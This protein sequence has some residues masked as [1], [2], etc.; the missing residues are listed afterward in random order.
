MNCKLITVFSHPEVEGLHKLIQS[1]KKFGWAHNFVPIQ[2]AWQGFGTKLKTVYEYLLAN[3]HV[4]Y[5][6][7]C[8]AYDVVILSTMEEAL[9]KLDL[10]KITFSAEKNCWPDT[11]L[12]KYYEPI[13]PGKWNYLN[14]GLYFA[15]R[16]KFMALFNYEMPDYATDDQLWASSQYLFNENSGIVLDRDCKVFQSYSFIA[17]DDFQYTRDGLLYNNKTKQFP[18]FVHGNGTTD[19]TKI[20]EL[21]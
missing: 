3:P 13:E 19:L 4:D 8:D 21:I 7:F 10:D 20:Y 12:E 15:P 14:S 2:T 11:S 6:F 16:E 9:S 1:A 18:T 17:D 5:F